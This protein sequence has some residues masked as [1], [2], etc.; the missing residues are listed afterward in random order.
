M[1]IHESRAA[2]QAFPI[3]TWRDAGYEHVPHVCGFCCSAQHDKHQAGA[4]ECP[5]CTPE[6]D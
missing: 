5:K 3:R 4:C 2:A 1:N 6:N